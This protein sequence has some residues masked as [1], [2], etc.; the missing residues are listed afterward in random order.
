MKS[1]FV[2]AKHTRRWVTQS[3]W[4]DLSLESFPKQL[5]VSARS[6]LSFL[7]SFFPNFL[8][9]QGPNLIAIQTPFLHLYQFTIWSPNFS[10]NS[11]FSPYYWKI[12]TFRVTDSIASIFLGGRDHWTDPYWAFDSGSI[13]SGPFGAQNSGIV[14][15]LK[16][17][18]SV[19]CGLG[20][21]IGDNGF[22]SKSSGIV[23]E[24]AD[25]RWG[26]LRWR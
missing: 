19:I 15:E 12:S 5:S 25:D 24:V 11:I 21:W 4:R 20:F 14:R 26:Y 2:S 8:S 16:L 9:L 17:E 22:K 1:D 13:G 6:H 7:A 10:I 3:H 23:L 18:F